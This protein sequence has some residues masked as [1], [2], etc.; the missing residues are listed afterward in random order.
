MGKKGGLPGPGPPRVPEGGARLHPGQFRLR[1]PP[2]SWILA[3]IL[4]VWVAG[5]KF[6]EVLKT[7]KKKPGKTQKNE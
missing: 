4:G 2:G 6:S 5:G 7:K 1:G 3:Q